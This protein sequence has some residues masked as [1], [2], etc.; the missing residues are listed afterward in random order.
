MA[1]RA[2]SALSKISLFN[3]L[4]TDDFP[5]VETPRIRHLHNS[6]GVSIATMRWTRVALSEQ[7]KWHISVNP[8]AASGQVVQY[9][10]S[11]RVFPKLASPTTPT[12]IYESVCDA[13]AYVENVYQVELSMLRGP[14]LT[15]T[16]IPEPPLYFHPPFAAPPSPAPPSTATTPITPLAPLRFD[17][18]AT[19]AAPSFSLQAQDSQPGNAPPSPPVLNFGQAPTPV[20][21]PCRQSTRPTEARRLQLENEAQGKLHPLSNLLNMV[22]LLRRVAGWIH[23]KFYQA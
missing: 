3:D 23:L 21:P 20:A 17:Q 2:I 22:L 10:G 12:A 18:A 13:I 8:L 19:P 4:V 9:D 15:A 7:D 1:A 5:V 11:Q 16:V 14:H 6:R